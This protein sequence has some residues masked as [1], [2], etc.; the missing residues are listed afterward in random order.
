MRIFK[1]WIKERHNPQLGCY[2]VGLGQLSKTAARKYERPLYGENIMH[3]FDTES[4]Y[5]A[6]LDELR[7]AGESVQ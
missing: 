2:Y 4:A 3:S 7:A 1:Y 6:R 5:Q